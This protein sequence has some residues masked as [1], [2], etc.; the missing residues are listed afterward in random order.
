MDRCKALGWNDEL[1]VLTNVY[2]IAHEEILISKIS[3]CKP[4]SLIP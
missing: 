2:L 1:L 4:N 3:V